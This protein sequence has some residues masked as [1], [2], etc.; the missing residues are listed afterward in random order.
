MERN[1]KLTEQLGSKL[2]I[3]ETKDYNWKGAEIQEPKWNYPKTTL[4]Y[5]KKKIK[6][7]EWCIICF[8]FFEKRKK[9][10]TCVVAFSF[11]E[12]KLK[13]LQI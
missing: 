1:L 10:A 2:R 11:C 12:G 8:F 3:L 4:F 7:D 13:N 6:R 9:I 5:F